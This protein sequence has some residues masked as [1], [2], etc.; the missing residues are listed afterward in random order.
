M[1]APPA[2]PRDEGPARAIGT[3]TGSRLLMDEYAPHF[4][5]AVVH[6]EVFRAVPVDCYRAATEVD[7]FRAP[8]PGTSGPGAARHPGSTARRGAD[9]EGAPLDGVGSGGTPAHLPARGP[10]RFGVDPPR[11]DA[12]GRGGP[13][14]GE[15]PVEGGRGPDR[16]AAHTR[17][18]HRLRR[19]GL[20]QDRGRPQ[21]RPSRPT[22][23]SGS[24]RSLREPAP[25]P[26][27]PS[28]GRS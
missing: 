10:G 8:L 9:T 11:R 6:S 26:R 23:P 24:T 16:R 3:S 18:V 22:S 13:R 15:P 7:L 1:S 12:R 25:A 20:R 2:E 27:R 4:D 5:V 21:G 19:A 28:T 17:R 14:S